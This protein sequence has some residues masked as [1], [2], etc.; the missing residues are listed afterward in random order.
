MLFQCFTLNICMFLEY[1]YVDLCTFSCILHAFSCIFLIVCMLLE[2]FYGNLYIFISFHM[3]SNI[4]CVCLWLLWLCL[5]FIFK[6]FACVY[7]WFYVLHDIPS[8]IYVKYAMET[9]FR[10]GYHWYTLTSL[11]DMI[12]ISTSSVAR[13]YTEVCCIL[14]EW[15]CIYYLYVFE[16]NLENYSCFFHVYAWIFVIFLVEF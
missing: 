1:F 10:N 2:Y 7:G 11:V 4:L 9:R 6:V 12:I 8:I 16:R 15:I 5:C 13:I 3:S 14:Q